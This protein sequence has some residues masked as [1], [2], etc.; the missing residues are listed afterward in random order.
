MVFCDLLL[1]RDI[2][3]LDARYIMAL[4]WTSQQPFGK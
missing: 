2:G 1:A 4:P 3:A